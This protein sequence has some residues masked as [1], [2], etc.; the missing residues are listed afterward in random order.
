[1]PEDPQHVEVNRVRGGG[2]FVANHQI[3][4]EGFRCQTVERV[5]E[6]EDAPTA[7]GVLSYLSC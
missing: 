5:N 7:G 2:Q 1:M 3:A 4:A 6:K